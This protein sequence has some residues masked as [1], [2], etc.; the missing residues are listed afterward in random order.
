MDGSPRWGNGLRRGYYWRCP[1]VREGA[2]PRRW[3]RVKEGRGLVV[4]D[5][6]V[7]GGGGGAEVWV[8]LLPG[9]GG[10]GVS[11]GESGGVGEASA[12]IGGTAGEVVAVHVFAVAFCF[13]G[14]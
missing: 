12:E 11:P 13:I 9:N 14:L 5:W 1:A 7:G 4:G 8:R 2:S 3:E 10:P 6:G